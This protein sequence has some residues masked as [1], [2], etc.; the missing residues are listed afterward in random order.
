MRYIASAFLFLFLAALLPAQVVGAPH[1]VFHVNTPNMAQYGSASAGGTG[2]LNTIA[3]AHNSVG[4]YV[5]FG[6]VL[7]APPVTA[8]LTP[9]TIDSDPLYLEPAGWLDQPQPMYAMTSNPGVEWGYLQYIPNNPALI[10][11]TVYSQCA[12]VLSGG[13]W[14]ITHAWATTLTP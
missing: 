1:P 8:P 3:A 12:I 5:V 4:A 10:G 14:A 11:L 7:A 13:T 2:F 6:T 9:Q